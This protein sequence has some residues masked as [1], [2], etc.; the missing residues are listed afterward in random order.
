VIT[1]DFN[2]DIELDAIVA[3]A[4]D[5]TIS[6]LL[7]NSDGAFKNQTTFSTGSDPCSINRW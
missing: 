4:W 2:Q 7:G 1:D 3:N 5:H 6:I